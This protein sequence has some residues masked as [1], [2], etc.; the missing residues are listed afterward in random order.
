MDECRRRTQPQPT[1]R[2]RPISHRRSS[3]HANRC[4]SQLAARRLSTEGGRPFRS[5]GAAGAVATL[6]RMD[7]V[8][9]FRAAV[10][11]LGLDPAV[12]RFPEGTRTA[13]DAAAAVGCDVACIVKSLVFSAGGA[14]V[15]VLTSGANRVDEAKVAALLGVDHLGKADAALVREAT[16]FAIGGTPPF[17]HPR[18]LQ[19]LVDVD[20]LDHDELWAAAG[21]PDTCFPI[22][23]AQLVDLADATPAD[24]ARR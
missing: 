13:V 7:A 1:H 16:G 12:Q 21:N 9:R 4:D 6:R 15:L 3:P 5:L 20:L 24:V 22:S 10:E 8:D 14:P 2:R 17:G 23:P 18:R 19:T 11:P